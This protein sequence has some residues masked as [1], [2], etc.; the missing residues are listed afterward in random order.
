MCYLVLLTVMTFT[1]ATIHCSLGHYFGNI[2]CHDISI[3]DLQRECDV[4]ETECEEAQIQ[5][6]FVKMMIAEINEGRRF[7]LFPRPHI[8]DEDNTIYALGSCVACGESLGSVHV[9]GSFML[10]CRHQYHP[11]YF[12]ATLMKKDICVKVGCNEC[13]SK[14]VKTWAHKGHVQKSKPLSCFFF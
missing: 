6:G 11:L 9:V 5:S 8:K 14:V 10:V 2:Y 1:F 13:I 7:T 4:L 12:A 3:F